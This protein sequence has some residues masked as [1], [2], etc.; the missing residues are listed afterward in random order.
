MFVC[1]LFYSRTESKIYC[2]Y[3]CTYN[4]ELHRKPKCV[5]HSNI[6]RK[7]ESVGYYGASVNC[8]SSS[9]RKQDQNQSRLL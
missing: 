5:L 9:I 3:V 8:N 2:N 1:V 6:M 4:F 7:K